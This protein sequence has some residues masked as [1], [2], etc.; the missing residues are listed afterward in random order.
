M[1]KQ[2]VKELNRALGEGLKVLAKAL[3]ELPYRYKESR[4]FHKKVEEKIRK[5]A[6]KTDGI[7]I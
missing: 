2:E 3:R 5:G 6:R 1:V 4:K 7:S